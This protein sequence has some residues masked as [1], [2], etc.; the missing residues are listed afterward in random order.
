MDL[1][2]DTHIWLWSFL[3]PVRVGKRVLH[4]MRNPENKVWLSPVST[5][6]ALT[7]NTKGRIR[8]PADVGTWIYKATAPLLEAPLT[9]EIAVAS[10]QLSWIHKDPAD[11]LLAATAKLLRLT[12]VTADY[13]MLGLGEISTLANR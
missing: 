6:E 11:R 2:L 10:S 12:L 5:W 3:E 8:L 9:H 7:L 1:L 4:E 13:E